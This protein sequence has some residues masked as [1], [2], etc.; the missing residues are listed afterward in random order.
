MNSASAQKNWQDEV[1]EANP[2]VGAENPRSI[3]MDFRCE[4]E[5]K[6]GEQMQT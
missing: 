6:G 1:L 2:F 5:K 3:Q 4:K